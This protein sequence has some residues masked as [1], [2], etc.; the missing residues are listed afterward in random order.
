M[1]VF[2]GKYYLEYWYGEM[3]AANTMKIYKFVSI[4]GDTLTAKIV[5]PTLINSRWMPSNELGDRT[6][7]IKIVPIMGKGKHKQKILGFESPRIINPYDIKFYNDQW[8]LSEND[9]FMLTG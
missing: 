7:K 5:K 1:Q 9:P 6:Y 8:G 2:I 3:M 4:N